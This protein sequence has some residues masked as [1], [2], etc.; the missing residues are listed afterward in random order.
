MSQT[1]LLYAIVVLNFLI[2]FWMIK[3]E[4]RLKKFFAGKKAKDL[5]DTITVLLADVNEL[6]DK[7]G[8]SEENIKN[9]N[10]RLRKAISNVQ[11]IRFNPFQDSGSNQS[12]AIAFLNEDGDGV[13]VS[14]LY[15][16]ERVSVFAKPVDQ[17]KSTY[18]LSNEE[19]E[20]IT[21]AFEKK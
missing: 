4:M 19:Q 9:M 5:E 17:L 20:A 14:S 12:F 11:T 2:I 1:I 15:S 3:T 13:V 8:I 21:K 6:K 16:R 18:E 7:N 10:D